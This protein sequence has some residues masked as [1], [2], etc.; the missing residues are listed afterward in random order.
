MSNE[1]S[2]YLKSWENRKRYIDFN[3]FA[4][5]GLVVLYVSVLFKIIDI[6]KKISSEKR[7]TS[8]NADSLNVLDM[9]YIKIADAD[10]EHNRVAG[11]LRKMS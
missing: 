11:G 10:I 6:Y 5:I 4:S 9:P 2:V 7:Q 3:Y 8:T 1:T